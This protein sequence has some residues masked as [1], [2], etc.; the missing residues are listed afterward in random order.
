VIWLAGAATITALIGIVIG[1]WA[2]SPSK[3]HVR[4]GK[5]SRIPYYGMKRWHMIFGLCFGVIACSWTFSGMLSMDPFPLLQGALD[6]NGARM[7][8]ALTGG[9]VD[10]EAFAAKPPQAALSDLAPATRVKELE[11]TSFDGEPIYLAATVRDETRIIP[12]HGEPAMQFEAKRVVEALRNASRPATLTDVRVVTKYEAYYVDRH[13]RLPLPVVFARLNDA[14][15][16]MYYVDL[17][18]GRVIESYDSNSRWNRWLYH[19][20]HSLDL[21]WLY[22]HRPAWDLIVLFLMLGGAALSVTAIMLA[23]RVMFDKPS[24]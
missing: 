23:F 5:A 21:P 22:E 20:L 6:E 7:E 14:R 1:I 4:A 17:K 24:S 10:L 19:G 15:S 16:S 2:Y 11:L 3:V 12:V 13:G 9:A 18:T 8:Q